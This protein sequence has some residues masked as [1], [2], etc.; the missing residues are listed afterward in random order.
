MR[1]VFVLCAL[2]SS[3]ALAAGPVYY[4]PPERTGAGILR[5]ITGA[6]NDPRGRVFIP[7]GV[8]RVNDTIEL[9]ALGPVEIEGAASA[10]L[11][12]EVNGANAVKLEW[13]GPPNKPMI[14]LNGF[15]TSIS[16]VTLDGRGV[17]SVGI[18]L[19]N[20]PQTGAAH[21]RLTDVTLMHFTEACYQAG[22]KPDDVCASDGYFERVNFWDAPSGFLC[23][24][25][26]SVAHTFRNC[27]IGWCDVGLDFERGGDM[28][29][30]GGG[31]GS[32]DLMFRL[33]WAAHNTGQF[34]IG[35]TRVEN[36][37][38]KNKYMS[39]IDARMERSDWSM[40]SAIIRLESFRMCGGIYP[41]VPDNVDT[42]L[43]KI[44]AGVQVISDSCL[45]KAAGDQMQWPIAEMNGVPN[46]GVAVLHDRG[47]IWM[48]GLDEKKFK[49]KGP[50][51]LELVEPVSQLGQPVSPPQLKSN[52]P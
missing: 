9:N 29:F 24:H 6:R 48:G 47:S 2:F 39:L 30:S 8:Y 50:V 4:E 3:V 20:S 16:N 52:T 19:T 18:L 37:G 40:D 45:Y 46:G 35:P 11:F 43:F 1:L 34:H 13:H 15:A 51:R 5:A 44:G 25:A 14:R 7:G 42:P 21:N 41:N 36:N 17:A 23:K 22:E 33:R 12:N 28:E 10:S 38:K 27:Q 26:Q 32:T 49:T 31:I